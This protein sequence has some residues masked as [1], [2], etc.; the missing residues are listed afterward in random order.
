MGCCFPGGGG[1]AG[2]SAADAR[3]AP[4]SE[5]FYVPEPQDLDSAVPQESP[6]CQG[7]LPEASQSESL[8]VLQSTCTSGSPLLTTRSFS[9]VMAGQNPIDSCLF[10]HDVSPERSPPKAPMPPTSTKRRHQRSIIGTPHNLPRGRSVEVGVGRGSFAD[11][12]LVGPTPPSRRRSVAVRG[13]RS[14]SRGPLSPPATAGR[15]RIDLPRSPT[16]RDPVPPPPPTVTTTAPEVLDAVSRENTSPGATPVSVSIPVVASL[17]APLDS[18]PSDPPITPDPASDPPTPEPQVES[19]TAA[20]A[21]TASRRPSLL[22]G[23]L[24]PPPAGSIGFDTSKPTIRQVAVDGRAGR[25]AARLKRRN[26]CC[27]APRAELTM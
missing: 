11:A 18:M 15:G 21:R 6:T 24:P 26:P 19:P 17:L 1:G 8:T 23:D 5:H 2:S 10:P 25:T 4:S 20:P 27:D 7:F 9:P 22:C 13:Q 3:E 14:G 16:V 12:V